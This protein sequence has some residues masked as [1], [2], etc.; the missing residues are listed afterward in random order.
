MNKRILFL[1]PL[2]IVL[3]F[4]S[5]SCAKNDFNHDVYHYI[6]KNNFANDYGDFSYLEDNYVSENIHKINLSTS[7]KLFRVKSR[8]QP[9]IDFRDNIVLVPSELSYQFEW[10]KKINIITPTETLAFD[11]DKINKVNYDNDATP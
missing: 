2:A 10:A 9:L 6:E 4:V 8:K 5:L 1:S 11:N 3:P 7:A